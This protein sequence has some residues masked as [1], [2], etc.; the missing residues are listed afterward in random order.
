MSTSLAGE[1]KTSLSVRLPK[2]L[3]SRAVDIARAQRVSVSMFVTD[4]LEKAVRETEQPLAQEVTPQN[5]KSP[6]ADSGPSWRA[7]NDHRIDLIFKERDHGL[8]AEEQAELA[9]LQT[10]ADRQIDRRRTLDFDALAEFEEAA[11]RYIERG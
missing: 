4:L 10:E 1:E 11:R 9:Q 2:R 5:G 3:K 8:T 6:A 7:R